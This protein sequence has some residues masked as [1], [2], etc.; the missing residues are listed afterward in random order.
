MTRTCGFPQSA[1]GP[2]LPNDHK[3]ISTARSK[4]WNVNSRVRQAALP[5]AYVITHEVA[6]HVQNLQAS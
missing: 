5:Q 4:T 1:T 6:D 3:F 2:S